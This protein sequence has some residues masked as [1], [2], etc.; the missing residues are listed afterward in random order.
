MNNKTRRVHI[1]LQ[2]HNIVHF[3]CYG[4][5]WGQIRIAEILPWSQKVELCI[6]NQHVSAIDEGHLYSSF[7]RDFLRL[8]Y[9]STDA[10]YVVE[11]IHRSYPY[12][13]I[14]VFDKDDEV[15]TLHSLS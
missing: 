2:K 11:D 6:L 7:Q 4:T 3:L 12:V 8:R 5:L 9:F 1:I 14:F 13:E 10:I 15:I